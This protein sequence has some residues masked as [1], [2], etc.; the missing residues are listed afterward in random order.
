MR[1]QL[2]LPEEIHKHDFATLYYPEKHPRLKIR[3]LAMMHL[4]SGN[5]YKKVAQMVNMSETSILLWIR[6]LAKNGVEGLREKSGRGRTLRFPADK[7]DAFKQAVL[8]AQD[9]KKGGRI[10]GKDVKEI[11]LNEFNVPLQKSSVY[12]LLHKVGLSWVSSRSR[13][14]KQDLEAQAAFKKTSQH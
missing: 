7:Y 14:P 8:K 2:I 4:K 11:L 12:A 3:L 6:H 1:S 5:H 13:H 10:M 9:E